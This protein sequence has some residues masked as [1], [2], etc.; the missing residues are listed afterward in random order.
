MII[1]PTKLLYYRPTVCM[2]G[3]SRN[4]VPRKFRHLE[5]IFTSKMK[6]YIFCGGKFCN[7]GG[8]F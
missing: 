8:K 6:K 3:K 4:L 1:I 5:G 7:I 2:P